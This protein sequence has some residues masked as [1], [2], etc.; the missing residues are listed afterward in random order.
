M[1]YIA[2]YKKRYLIIG[3]IM[4]IF[5]F[6]IVKFQVKIN[7]L[8][9]DNKLLSNK[10]KELSSVVAPACNFGHCPKYMSFN[11]DDDSYSES[12]VEVSTTMNKGGGEIW[13]IDNDGKVV[14]KHDGGAHIGYRVPCYGL[15]GQDDEECNGIFISYVSEFDNTGLYPSESTTEEWRYRDGVYVLIDTVVETIKKYEPK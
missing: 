4:A 11:T 13:I 1:I 8:I 3:V 14:F 9:S 2:L 7:N 12:V 15:E 6:T 10:V 5:V